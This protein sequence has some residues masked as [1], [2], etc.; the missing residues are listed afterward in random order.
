MKLILYGFFG[1]LLALA[2][3]G[4]LTAVYVTFV[5]AEHGEEAYEFINRQIATQRPGPPIQASPPTK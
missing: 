5:R 1:T 4:V 3:A 2:L